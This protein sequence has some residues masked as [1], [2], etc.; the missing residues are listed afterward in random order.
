MKI[1]VEGSASRH[2]GVNIFRAE[3]RSKILCRSTR[4][5][6]RSELALES[7]AA[8]ILAN[9]PELGIVWVDPHLEMIRT[10][11]EKRCSCWNVET[12]ILQAHILDVGAF[13]Y[14]DAVFDK[15]LGGR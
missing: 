8:S 6:H 12:D 7:R 1:N 15:F 5:I 11:V 3:F 13:A 4:K 2:C 9:E 10:T 14:S